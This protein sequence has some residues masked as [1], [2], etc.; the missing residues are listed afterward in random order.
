MKNFI[1][2][3]FIRHAIED[4]LVLVAIIHKVQGLVA[5]VLICLGG[6]ECGETTRG[7]STP[8]NLM[9]SSSFHDFISKN[10]FN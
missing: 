7:S 2:D 4:H 8:Y 10:I 9:L 3:G 5:G 6:F 1:C